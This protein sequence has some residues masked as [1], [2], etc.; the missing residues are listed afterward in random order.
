[1]SMNTQTL[2]IILFVYTT[3][4]LDQIQDALRKVISFWE[5]NNRDIIG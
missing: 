5:W 3:L 2:M 4:T 1:M